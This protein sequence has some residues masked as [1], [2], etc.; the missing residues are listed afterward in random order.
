MK[1]FSAEQIKNWDAATIKN[2]PIESQNLMN[3]AAEKF[4]NWF[5]KKFED[6]EKTVAILCGTGNN[7]GDGVAVARLLH[8]QFFEVK[9]FVCDFAGKHSSDFDWQ[10]EQLPPHEQ[11]E[12]FHLK[13][14]AELPALPPDWLVV[15]AIFGT[16]LSRKLDGEHEKLVK[17]LNLLSNFKISIDLPAGLFAD[18]HS[19]CT[20]F[21]ADETFTFETP[22]L[23]FFLRENSHRVGNWHF[24]S[25]GLDKNFSEKTETPY[26]FLTA[27]DARQLIRPRQKFDHKG[28]F[29]HALLI[30]GSLGKMGAT[31][32]AT[33]ACLR[34]GA[35]LVTA[36]VPRCGLEI[37][38][39]AAPEAMVLP[40]ANFDFWTQ[41]PDFQNF[42]AV[43]IG[44]G[45]GKEAATA[46]AFPQFLEKI[47]FPI[48]ADADAL[49]L[50]SEN[51]DLLER[52]PKNS[53]LTP[54]PKEFE[55][56]FGK[57]END[58]ERLELLRESARRFE[59]FII[60]KGANSAVACPD[61]EVWF[62]STGNPGMATG[63]SG[64]VLTGILTGLL[65]QNY[66][67]KSAALLGV[68][69]HGLAGDLAALEIGQPSLVAGDL[70]EF[71]GKS[72]LKLNV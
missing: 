28:S 29:G 44:C 3:R 49:N 54:H 53:I 33:R 19:D 27:E 11:V 52:L 46:A 35:G 50:L 34:S 23:A 65:A 17:K 20:T 10:I 24:E 31:V 32:L 67:P 4:A 9:V 56:L 41:A 69:W 42:R 36:N 48:V 25:I 7:G 66:P 26:H 51:R 39:I 72:W 16:G 37:L 43:G 59:V 62:N 18:Q 14:A 63:G 30:G 21:L 38:Q 5:A 61:G 22:K 8:Y 58:F 40:D 64:D 55:R 6:S 15:E 70:V 2:E 57:T 1:I 47:N 12:I 71:L 68:F 60:L 13:N 45:L